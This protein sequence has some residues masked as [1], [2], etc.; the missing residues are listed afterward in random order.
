MSFYEHISY[1]SKFFRARLHIGYIAIPYTILGF[2]IHWALT[3]FD[4]EI[5]FLLDQSAAWW[6]FIFASIIGFFYMPFVFMINDYFDAP[7]DALDSEKR[8][9]NPFCSERFDN[10]QFAQI[11]I[12][13]LAFVPLFLGFLISWQA[14]L[15]TIIAII[16]GT[17]YSAPPFRFKARPIADFMVHGF[18]L[19]V[20]FFSLGFFSFF[21]ENYNPFVETPIFLFFLF[22]TMI[23]ASW[24]H[25]ISALKDYKVDKIGNQHTTAVVLGEGKTLILIQ[26]LT[27]F[28]LLSPFIYF[29]IINTKFLLIYGNITVF[30]LIIL[31]LILPISYV[32]LN[33]ILKRTIEIKRLLSARYRFYTVYPFTIIAIFLANPLLYS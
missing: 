31:T 10:Q 27:F 20:Y 26:F 32:L 5:L 25:L 15:F 6:R 7:Y 33:I 1:Y 28:L 17:F 29:F 8:Q 30:F 23:D 21:R 13:F 19:G 2:S 24:I 4:F 9:R 12:I 11:F 18:S 3:G 22:F 16:L 14:G